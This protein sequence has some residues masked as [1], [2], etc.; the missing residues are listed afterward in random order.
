MIRQ[1]AHLCNLFVSDDVRSDCFED[2]RVARGEG[3]LVAPLQGTGGP[4]CKLGMK[5]CLCTLIVRT[6]SCSRRKPS[7]DRVSFALSC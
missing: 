2:F 5:K 7:P 1:M 3:H 6:S 4:P